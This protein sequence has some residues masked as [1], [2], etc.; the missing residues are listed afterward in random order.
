MFI[1]AIFTAAIAARVFPAVFFYF[2]A[3]CVGMFFDII[4]FFNSFMLLVG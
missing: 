1:F 3:S 4:Y 2:V